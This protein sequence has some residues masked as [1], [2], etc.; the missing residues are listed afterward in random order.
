MAYDQRPNSAADL[1]NGATIILS[2]LVM[3]S[4]GSSTMAAFTAFLLR[5]RTSRRHEKE[6]R[7]R[8]E[9]MKRDL[10]GNTRHNM[11]NS[12]DCLQR[13]IVRR[14]LEEYSR[15]DNYGVNGGKWELAKITTKNKIIMGWTQGSVN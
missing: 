3:P 9:G 11:E 7:N 12:T 6:N 2:T 1:P 10:Y 5:R 14:R 8:G 4:S 15:L 13:F